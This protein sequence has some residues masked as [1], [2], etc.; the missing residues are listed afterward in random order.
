MPQASL[1]CRVAL[2]ILAGAVASLL[3]GQASANTLC[4]NQN[5]HSGCY[6]TIQAAVDQA[7]PGGTILIAPGTYREDVDIK[8]P[9]SLVGAGAAQTVIDAD[10]LANGIYVDGIDATSPL[11]AVTVTGFTVENAKYEGILAANVSDL[12]LTK[13]RVIGNDVELD[14]GETDTESTCPGLT[15]LHP[16]ETNETFDCGEGIHLI[17]VDHSTVSNNT[18]EQN[19]GGI[20]LRDETGPTSNNLIKANRVFDNPYDCGITLAS[21]KA[22]VEGH[23]PFGVFDNTIAENV[24]SHNGYAVG[25]AGAGVGLFAPG[26]FNRTSGNVVI[27]NRLTDNG[28]P[29]IAIHNHA[30]TQNI[31]LDDNVITGNYI[32]GNGPDS[33][34]ELSPA[35]QVPTGIS[36]LG[37]S[38]IRGTVI[39]G[40][41]FA[42]EATDIAINNKGNADAVVDA[43]LNDLAG[44]GI[45]VANLDG[46]S[47]N[48][49]LNWWGCANGPGAS[50]CSSV[51][52]D[53]VVTAPFQ[54]FR[55]PAGR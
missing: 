26:A 17:G 51:S 24:S 38:L 28:L 45:G 25:G 31:N 13:N 10:G 48:A 1:G 55:Y 37:V 41:V 15:G 2:D 3:A 46:G 21:H 8:D 36:L 52:G 49:T 4:V 30:P 23:A 33:D 9:L 20:L 11:A 19:A 47:V 39:S 22:A 44:L 42:R 12:T 18:V 29:G 50:G 27:G 14:P 32:A 34:A 7:D 5:P 54:P 53:N 6:A 43:H 35:D 40:N 16:F